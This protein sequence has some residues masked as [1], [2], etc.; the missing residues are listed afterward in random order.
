MSFSFLFRR[1][2][3]LRRLLS[4]HRLPRIILLLVCSTLLYAMPSQAAG[5]SSGIR[6]VDFEFSMEACRNSKEP[7]VKVDHCTRVISQ[8][9]DRKILERAF[10]RRG[11]A[12]MD[13]KQFGE[14]AKDFT[15]VIRLNPRIA[16]YFDNRQ[17][18]YKEMGR[19]ADA[20]SDANRAVQLA[21]TYSFVY[22]S[23]GLVF[24]DLGRYD[25]AIDDY[26]KGLSLDSNDSGLL[27]DRGETFVK[28]GKLLEGIADF[29]RA[30]NIDKNATSALRERGLAYKLLGNFDA[31]RSDLSLFLRT[32]PNDGEI[33]QALLDMTSLPKRVSPAKTEEA[34]IAHPSTGS[35]AERRESPQGAETRVALIIGNGQYEHADKLANPVTDARNMRDALQ[36]LQFRVVYG[37]NLDKRSLERTIGR[38]AKEVEAA[39]VALIFFA[40][41]GATFGDIPYVVPVDAQFSAIEDIPYELVPVETLIGELRRAKG[42]RIAILDACR[43]NGAERELKRTNSRGGQIT[44][45]LAPVKNPE[46]LILAYATQYLSTADDGGLDGDSPFTAALLKNIAKPGLDVKEL[47]YETAREVIA[48]TDGRQRPE[49]SISFYDAYTLAGPT[50]GTPLS[51]K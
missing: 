49:I 9:S 21:P 22:R 28:A 26:T 5:R 48:K 29:T 11:L 40:G 30:L 34:A 10:N 6:A 44:R 18:A 32:Q 39:D 1:Y 20:L 43:D 37:E 2:S 16:G 17:A 8:S 4:T 14:A 3:P 46:G 36:N 45:G 50:P 7:A 38:F 15:E 25:F 51:A 33:V 35:N 13:L 41:H 42:V 23:R 24:T 31:A 47:F 27:A 19:L 12:Y